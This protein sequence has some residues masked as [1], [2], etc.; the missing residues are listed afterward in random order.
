MTGI[1]LQ[2]E[3]NFQEVHGIEAGQADAQD[4]L[5]SFV[6]PKAGESQI[7]VEQKDLGQGDGQDFERGGFYHQ[8]A[9]LDQIQGYFGMEEI[10]SRQA[11]QVGGETGHFTRLK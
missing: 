9:L 4:G 8:M 10:A 6:G 2:Y 11:A 3:Q 7:E 5:D 1:S